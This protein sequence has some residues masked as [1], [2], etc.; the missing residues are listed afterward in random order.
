MFP[1]VPYHALPKLN[2]LIRADLPPANPSILHAYREVWP[3]L[4]RQLRYED[5][6]LRRELPPT[7]RPY[8]AEFHDLPTEAAE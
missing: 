4:K 7:A 1:M 8:R 5:A 6:F 3:V 2:A